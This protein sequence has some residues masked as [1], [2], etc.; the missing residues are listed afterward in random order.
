MSER[1]VLLVGL[2]PLIG[3]AFH[4]RAGRAGLRVHRMENELASAP[5]RA[6]LVLCVL[7]A[8]GDE[9]AIYERVRAV[10]KGIRPVPLVL[11][12]REVRPATVVRLIR[13][14]VAD[15]IGLSRPTEDLV[16]MAFENLAETGVASGTEAIGGESEAMHE[17]RREVSAVARTRSTV[18]L[19]GE[20]GT[21]KGLVARTIH[22]LS[23]SRRSRF[24]H[25]DCAALSPTVIES[26]LFGHERGAF[27]GASELRRGRFELAEGG[28]L[29]LD[30]IGDLDTLLQAKL[31]RV[32]QDRCYERVGGTKTLQMTA[33]VIAATNRDLAREKDEGRF[34][35]DLY[36][37]LNVF[38]IRIPPLRER[39]DDVPGLVRTGLERISR[40]LGVPSP[41]VSDGFYERLRVH[42]WPGNVRE[43]FNLLERCLV[44]RRVD[45]LEAEDLD[46]LLEPPSA[47]PTAA[48]PGTSPPAVR[49]PPGPEERRRIEQVLRAVGGNVTRAARRLGMP[50]G[51]LRY[52]IDRYGLGG[53][54][55]RD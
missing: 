52:K 5:G 4:A 8:R 16:S 19:I 27:T 7:E 14:G 40:E 1:S 44:H 33:R 28:T 45:T 32:M 12:V 54:L 20:T 21:G 23:G 22:E 3:E 47:L 9:D 35:E 48:L 37:R 53:L 24:V 42:P 50:R 49:A 46:G 6:A 34:R 11:L 39:I 36:Y 43:L 10:L 18:L 31:L 51:T 29:F 38:R 26:E 15:V 30:E 25:V 13:M 2:S 41:R 55:P 17:V